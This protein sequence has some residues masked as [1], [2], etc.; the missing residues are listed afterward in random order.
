LLLLLLLTLFAVA[1]AADRHQAA[2]SVIDEGARGRH[3]CCHKEW[4]IVAGVANST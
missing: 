3:Q 4:H 2:N 1:A